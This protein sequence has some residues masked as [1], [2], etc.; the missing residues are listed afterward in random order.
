MLGSLKPLVVAALFLA[1]AAFAASPAQC[2]ASCKKDLQPRCESACRQHTTV[3]DEC[4]KQMCAMVT[5]RCDKICDD[6]PK[7]HK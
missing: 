7:K 3:A 1:G 5:K 4:I 2:K 6:P